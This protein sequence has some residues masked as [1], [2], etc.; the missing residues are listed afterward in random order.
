MFLRGRE[1]VIQGHNVLSEREGGESVHGL[2]KFIT[3]KFP[4][5]LR[6]EKLKHQ[7]I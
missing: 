7:I 3:G 2:D 4:T 5:I 6:R 1:G